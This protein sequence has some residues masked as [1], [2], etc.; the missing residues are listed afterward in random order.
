VAF[1]LY[2]RVEDKFWSRERLEKH[3]EGTSI[4]IIPLIAK[5]QY[6]TPD[7]LCALVKTPS[8]FYGGPVEGAYLRI[9][10]KDW[11]VKRGKIVRSDF[12]SG[13]KHWSK[14]MLEPNDL[15]KS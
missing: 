9:C 2:D 6:K 10:D 13:N 12:L 14:N 11:L 4:T 15:V 3:L 8:K 1:D 7:D 5:K